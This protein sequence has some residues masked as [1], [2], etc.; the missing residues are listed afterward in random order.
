MRGP[1]LPISSPVW[2]APQNISAMLAGVLADD[3][4]LGPKRMA[5]AESMTPHR[6]PADDR[7]VSAL[8]QLVGKNPPPLN[9]TRSSSFPHANCDYL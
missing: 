4:N 5:G 6:R 7:N 8:S 3:T 9:K 2:D 1:D